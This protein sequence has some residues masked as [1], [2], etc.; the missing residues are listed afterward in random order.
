MSTSLK[1]T[2]IVGL[3]K[4]LAGMMVYEKTIEKRAEKA[5]LDEANTILR[6]AMD[7]TPVETGTLRRSGTVEGPK[8]SA[9]NITVEIGF[10]T[11]YAAAVHENLKAKHA[12]GKAKFLEDP[13]NAAAPGM[14]ARLSARMK[15]GV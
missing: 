7:Q 11:D 3:D 12:T 6:E 14:P 1:I 8:V 2:R 15:G 10:N 5:L 13:V 9:K 4:V